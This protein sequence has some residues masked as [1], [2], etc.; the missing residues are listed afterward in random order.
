MGGGPRLRLVLGHRSHDPAGAPDARAMLTLSAEDERHPA[1][2]HGGE[3]VVGQ[4][5]LIFNRTVKVHRQWAT[6]VAGATIA[7]PRNGL[8]ASS[9]PSPRLMKDRA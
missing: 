9:F 3:N 5:R 8:S 1:A 4:L 6:K 2:M 7:I